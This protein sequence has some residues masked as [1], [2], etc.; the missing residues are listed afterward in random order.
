VAFPSQTLLFAH[1]VYNYLHYTETQKES[2]DVE[3]EEDDEIPRTTGPIP[4]P[5][6]TILGQEASQ[7]TNQYAYGEELN[8]DSGIL[9]DGIAR[10]RM[11]CST[12]QEN[13]QQNADDEDY[14][15]EEP[16]Y[17]FIVDEKRAYFKLKDGEEPSEVYP[18]QYPAKKAVT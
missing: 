1:H 17:E 14:E 7:A 10:M 4:D 16:E 2:R 15:K 6:T 3:S 11:S 13:Y 18:S 12:T 5:S 8:Q 9:A